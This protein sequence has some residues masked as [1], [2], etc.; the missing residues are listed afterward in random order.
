MNVY[1]MIRV[2][3][4]WNALSN[5]IIESSSLGVFKKEIVFYIKVSSSFCRFLFFYL[6]KIWY[7]GRLDH[8]GLKVV[9]IHFGANLSWR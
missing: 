2:I 4:E 9:K 5:E 7:M 8:R 1:F 3:T 6:Q